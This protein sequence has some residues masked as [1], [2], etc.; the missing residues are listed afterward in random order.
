MNEFSRG[1]SPI[2][3]KALENGVSIIGLTRGETTKFHHIE[4]MDKG[5]VL[6]VQF[7]EYTSAIKIKGHAL[8]K[9]INGE[10]VSG[11]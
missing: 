11:D 10:V 2:V 8:I 7:T 5:D 6:V 4:K 3:V 1:E 9:T